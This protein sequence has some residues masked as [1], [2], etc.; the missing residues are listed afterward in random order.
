MPESN[1]D[2]IDYFP[3]GWTEDI[4][5]DTHIEWRHEDDESILIR[6]EAELENENTSTI[7]YVSAITGHQDNGEEFVTSTINHTDE[8][9]AFETVKT[10]IYAMNGTLGRANGDSEFFVDVEKSEYQ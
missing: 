5:D 2:L 4:H 7:Y 9:L 6:L 1:T 10:L 8:A 3:N